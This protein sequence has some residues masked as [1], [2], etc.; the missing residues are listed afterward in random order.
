[1][2]CTGRIP[3]IISPFPLNR[4]ACKDLLEL[5]NLTG[6]NKSIIRCNKYV[7]SS[8]VSLEQTIIEYFNYC[9]SEAYVFN[10]YIKFIEIK[11][12]CRLHI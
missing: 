9:Y 1:M 11:D 10:F 5:L 8:Q 7:I 6:Y 2:L 4:K 3:C 12:N